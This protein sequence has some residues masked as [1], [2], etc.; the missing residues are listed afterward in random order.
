MR[1]PLPLRRAALSLALLA[2]LFQ[3]MPAAAEELAITVGLR[4]SV[5]SQVLGEERPLLVSLPGS[6]ASSP[7][8]RYPVL[9]VLDGESHF[10]HVSS[11]VEFLSRRGRLP[12]MIVVAVPNTKDRDR[13]LTPPFSKTER[14]DNGQL[15]IDV[16]PTA[17]G[18]DTF[19]RFFNEELIPTVDARYR[20]RPFRVLMGHSFGGL[21]AMHTLVNRPESFNAYVAISPSIHWNSAELVRKA[22]EAF[23]RLTAPGRIL[24]LDEDATETPNI[25]RLR[26]LTQ[27][28]KKRKLP[29]LTWHYDEVAD[30]DHGT[31]PHIG[32][33]AGLKFVFSG[34]KPAEKVRFSNDLAPLEAHYA[35]LSRRLG[36]P[37]PPPE[38]M[39]TNVGYWHLREKQ[40]PQALAVFERTVA[41]YPDSA[42]AHDSLG[43]ALEAAGRLQEALTHCERAVALGREHQDAHVPD[44]QKHADAVR[45]RLAAQPAP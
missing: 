12:E 3:A 28:M 26:T 1:P 23:S 41:L 39:L 17:G 14:A 22:P 21:F 32:A 5:Q 36:Y 35:A 24:Y 18:A 31:L 40:L 4:T 30:E 6:Y 15:L 37:M 11:M 25:N 9:Y 13:D 43:D 45:A 20:T 42:N 19:L 2:V 8:T 10:L 33:Y 7:T 34:W 44:Y 27:A 38:D 16:A 29:S